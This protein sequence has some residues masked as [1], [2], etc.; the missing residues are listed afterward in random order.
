MRSRRQNREFINFVMVPRGLQVLHL[1]GEGSA[2]GGGGHQPRGNTVL[3]E[4]HQVQKQTFPYSKNIKK[5]KKIYNYRDSLQL[6]ERNILSAKF[7]HFYINCLEDF[8][9]HTRISG[10][11]QNIIIIFSLLS[12]LLA[13]GITPAVTLYHWDLPEALQQQGN[14]II[15]FRWHCSVS[16]QSNPART[17][18]IAGGWL[19]ASVAD[20]FEEYARLCYTEFGEEVKFWITLNEPKETSIQGSKTEG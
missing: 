20:W 1:V 17:I 16:V 6:F 9:S 3:Q 8:P 14:S 10:P 12:E 19:N 18:S 4:S 13:A 2:P 5:I 7:A 15:T 11:L